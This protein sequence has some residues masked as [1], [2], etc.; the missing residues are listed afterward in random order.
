MKVPIPEL[1]VTDGLT[2]REILMISVL[3][4]FAKRY[5]WE[6]YFNFNSLDVKTIMN[7][8][9]IDAAHISIPF[10][11]WVDI[12]KWDRFN[13]MLKVKEDV[14]FGPTNYKRKESNNPLLKYFE[15][16]ESGTLNM[17]Y[18]LV[19]RL[20][21]LVIN[22]EEGF[23]HTKENNQRNMPRE[24]RRGFPS[25]TNLSYKELVQSEIENL[26]I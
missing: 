13:L 6:N 1:L 22:E 24:Y 17:A 19:G 23:Y 7:F 11:E 3:T 10:H 8:K 5:G 9:H 16:T 25:I 18:Y 12:V 15:L 26:N 20:N 2:Q 21:D 4:F 14:L